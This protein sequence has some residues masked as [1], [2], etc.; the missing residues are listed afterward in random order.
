MKREKSERDRRKNWKKELARTRKEF[1][2]ERKKRVQKREKRSTEKGRTKEK[3]EADKQ[4]ETYDLPYTRASKEIP[5]ESIRD[6]MIHTSDGRYV[7]IIEVLPINFLHRSASEQRNIIYSYMGY[8]KIAPAELQIKS[9]SKKADIGQYIEAVK[10]DMEAEEDGRCR[11]L[12]EDYI[13]LLRSVG[14]REAVTRR[15]FLV[16]SMDGRRGTESEI[17]ATLN[18]YAQSAKKYLYQC[19]NEVE[20]SENPTFDTV[21]MLYTLLNRKTSTT[22]SLS[23][24]LNQVAEWYIRENGE[25]ST[26][27]IPVTEYFAPR[28]LDFKHGKE[29][30]GDLYIYGHNMKN[31]TMFAMLFRYQNKNFWETHPMIRLDSCYEHREYRVFSVF[32]AE[33]TEWSK[34]SGLFYPAGDGGRIGK[35]RE[36]FLKKLKQRGQHESDVPL[37]RD[38]QFLFLVTCSYGT[39]NSRLVVA[40]VREDQTGEMRR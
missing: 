1:K 6:G 24:R 37:D 18:S 34:A 4:E 15:F 32:Q 3:P 21:E 36:E 31:G 33:E 5:V 9:I 7:K 17:A 28:R 22:V 8:L 38:S 40:A 20:M 26:A 35:K 30:N 19:G 16:F 12:Q 29:E 14:Y 11:M 39:E 2:R 27:R 23:E 10:K 25:E 13:K